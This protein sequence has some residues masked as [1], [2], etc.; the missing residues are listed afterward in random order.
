MS[1]FTNLLPL[2]SYCRTS[3]CVK[4]TVLPGILK[5]FEK[6]SGLLAKC[7]EMSTEIFRVFDVTSTVMC[8]A[9][10]VRNSDSL[11]MILSTICGKNCSVCE[12]T[13]VET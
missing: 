13:F 8:T 6:H 4:A 5:D 9:M 7:R 10:P 1:N 3:T 2:L 11:R 12:I